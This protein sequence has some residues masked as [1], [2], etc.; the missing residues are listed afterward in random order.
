MEDNFTSRHQPSWT[1]A[2]DGD[3]HLGLLVRSKE[4]VCNNTFSLAMI[5]RLNVYRSLRAYPNP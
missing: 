5:D 1:G 4:Q 3:F 2:N